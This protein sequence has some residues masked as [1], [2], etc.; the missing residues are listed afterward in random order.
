MIDQHSLLVFAAIFWGVVISLTDGQEKCVPQAVAELDLSPD[1]VLYWTVS[2]EEKCTITHFT[3][4]IRRTNTGEEHDFDVTTTSIDLSSIVLPC[5]YWLF[6][7]KAVSDTGTVGF[8]HLIYTQD[9]LKNE[10]RLALNYLRVDETGDHARLYWEMEEDLFKN[11]ADAFRI[12]IA[13]EASGPVDNF[14]VDLD[15]STVLDFAVPC[16]TYAFEVRALYY[17]PNYILKGPVMQTNHVEPERVLN[18]PKLR[19]VTAGPTSVN[20]TW[21]LDSLSTNRCPIK[22]FYVDGGDYFNISIPISEYNDKRESVLAILDALMP[23]SMYVLKVSVENSAGVS[24]Q[25]TAA[26]QTLDLLTPIIPEKC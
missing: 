10:S 17:G 1:R 13:D 19:G 15:T 25:T 3:V 4:N 26:V 16:A 7:L 14:T 6:G 21:S 22:I 18:P 8:D 23:S 24:N 11:C 9:H 5:V 12:S 2:P 20:T